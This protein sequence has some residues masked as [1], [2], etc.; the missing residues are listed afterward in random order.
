MDCDLL[1]E[2]QLFLENIE[3]PSDLEE[4]DISPLFEIHRN[5]EID[6]EIPTLMQVLNIDED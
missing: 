6:N 4:I 2:I 3:I 1:E 5:S